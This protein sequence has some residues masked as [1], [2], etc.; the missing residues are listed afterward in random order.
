MDLQFSER[1]R[2]FQKS[3]R[4][5]VDEE[6]PADLQERVRRGLKLKREDYVRWQRIL[7]A[8]GS[9]AEVLPSSLLDEFAQAAGGIEWRASSGRVHRFRVCSGAV[10]R[11]SPSRE[12]GEGLNPSIMEPL[13]DHPVYLALLE[14]YDV[15]FL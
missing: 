15:P 14:K 4:T 2:A 11:E 7:S 9:L 1:D 5:F 3:V 13:R 6:L 8:R 12:P 10:S